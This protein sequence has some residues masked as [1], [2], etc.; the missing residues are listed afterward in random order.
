MKFY[1][2]GENKGDIL[3]KVTPLVGLTVKRAHMREH[4]PRKKPIDFGNNS[5]LLQ[6]NFTD[7]IIIIRNK[8][9][10]YN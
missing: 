7:K 2:I 5:S 1:M 9:S 6:G 10:Y 3:I 4:H 8:L